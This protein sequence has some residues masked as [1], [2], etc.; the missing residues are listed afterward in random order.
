[1][2][3]EGKLYEDSGRGARAEALLRDP[4]IVGAFRELEDA[5][6]KA[7]RSTS[8]DNVAG[9]E[10]L[11]LAVNIVGKVRDHLTKVVMDGQLAQAE[12][13]AIEQAA[14]RQKAWHDVK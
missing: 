14:E 13:R 3:D 2:T 9:R 1:M 4:L 5:Y 7:W 11:F 10:K 6:T 12:L 8:I